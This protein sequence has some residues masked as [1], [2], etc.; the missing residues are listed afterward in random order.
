MSDTGLP[1]IKDNPDIRTLAH[2]HCADIDIEGTYP[3]LEDVMNISNETTYRELGTIQGFTDQ[4]RRAIGINLS[5]G[6]VNS[7]ELC[8]TLLGLPNFQQMEE[9]YLANR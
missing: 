6:V 3:N 8:T 1:L 4:D 2:P 9:I 5:G 7:V